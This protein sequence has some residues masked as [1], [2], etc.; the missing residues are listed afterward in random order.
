MGVF[1]SLG[2][3]P[4]KAAGAK[5][6][7]RLFGRVMPGEGDSVTATASANAS[8]SDTDQ[9]GKFNASNERNHQK[10]LEEDSN[11]NEAQHKNNTD[12]SSSPSSPKSQTNTTTTDYPQQQDNLTTTAK[13]AAAGDMQ[14]LQKRP[15]QNGDADKENQPP[16]ASQLSE[17]LARLELQD[18]KPISTS[19]KS[20][21]PIIPT[22]PIFTDPAVVAERAMHMKFTEAA[23]DMVSLPVSPIGPLSLRMPG[24]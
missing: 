12:S 19:P 24:L 15:T 17:S 1:K 8:A 20:V 3:S 6:I 5:A 23:L 2:L 18:D 9:T 4:A 16:S 13:P 21:T 22:A 14:S 10:E 11:S 7:R